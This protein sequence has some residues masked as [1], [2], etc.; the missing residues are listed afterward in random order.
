MTV[1]P[2]EKRSIEFAKVQ[3]MRELMYGSFR[4]AAVMRRII[5]TRFVNESSKDVEFFKIGI[6]RIT[7]RTWL[8]DQ[9]ELE[10]YWAFDG[11]GEQIGRS[12]AISENKGIIEQILK[13]CKNDSETVNLSE[14][15]ENIFKNKPA[16]DIILTNTYSTHEFWKM[17]NF[18]S[19]GSINR[20]PFCEGRLFNKIV[21]WSNVLPKDTTLMINSNKFAEI[22]EKK[23]LGLQVYED[24]SDI[25][26]DDLPELQNKNIKEFIRLLAHEI[27]GLKIMDKSAIIILKTKVNK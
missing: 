13:E 4:S 3:K 17:E 5:P 24:L 22:L 25:N 7:E 14:L 2:V 19:T 27:I 16:F 20:M 18:K 8:V 26:I 15:S 10:E 12:I 1:K 9:R 11:I 23:P 21:Y 6:N